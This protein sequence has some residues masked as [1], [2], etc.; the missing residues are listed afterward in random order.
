MLI[1]H[2]VLTC[3]ESAAWEENLLGGDA[4]KTWAAIERAGEGLG[5]AALKDYLEIRP[6]P[7]VFSVLV[8][9]GTGHNAADALMA[10]RLILRTLP[11]AKVTALLLYP[12]EKLRPLAL[13]ALDELEATGMERVNVRM[14]SDEFAQTLVNARF[15]LCIEG[16]LGMQM[17]PPLRAPAPEVFEAVSRMAIEMRAAVDLPAGLGDDCAPNGFAADFTYATGIAKKPVFDTQNIRATGRVRY[18]DIGFFDEARPEGANKLEILPPQS[19]AQLRALRPATSDKRANGHI[20]IVGGSHTMPGA[21][22]MA[23]MAALRAGAGLVTTFAPASLLPTIATSSPEAMWVPLPIENSSPSAAEESA[24]IVQ[25][26]S[27]RMTAMIIGPGLDTSAKDVRE[28]VSKLIRETNAPIVIDA[29]ALTPEAMT[30]VSARPTAFPKV[31]MTPHLGEFARIAGARV[32]EPDCDI[33]AELKTFSLRYHC[34]TLLKGPVT[35]ICDGTRLVCGCF[36]GP[37]LSRGGSGD[38]LSGILG[39]VAAQPD[40]NLFECACLA[41]L[42]HG[43]AA[44]RLARARGQKAVRTTEILDQLSPTIREI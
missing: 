7:D 1:T 38:I 22:C 43:E 25:R 30:A 19:L 41:A 9:L 29:S 10:A 3:A 42:W 4:A 34:V 17:K 18:I 26:F 11:F 16:V 5:K 12:R 36:G 44:E 37:T 24:G 33:D 40:A 35:R 28:L 13:H 31:V 21:V 23:T 8:L 2:P 15:N 14:W 20:F 6:I 27:A 39:A 32:L